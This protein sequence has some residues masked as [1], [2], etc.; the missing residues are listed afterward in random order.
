VRLSYAH[1]T[2]LV[3]PESLSSDVAFLQ[4]TSGSTADPKGVMITHA[5]LVA[6]A[7]HHYYICIHEYI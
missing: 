3:E 2:L 1:T 6:Q 7:C 4:Y 5:N